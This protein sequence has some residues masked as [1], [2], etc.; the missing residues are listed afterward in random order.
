MEK[1]LNR[2]LL[3]GEVVH[4][5]NGIKDDNRIENLHLFS[6]HSEH[7]K[8]HNLEHRQRRGGIYESFARIKGHIQ[9]DVRL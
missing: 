1:H 3:K 6:S 2:K 9:E 5:N 4:H 7:S 8:E